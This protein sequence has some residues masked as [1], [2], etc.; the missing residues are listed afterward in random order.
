MP[1]YV[2]N[3]INLEGNK[4]IIEKV[5]ESLEGKNGDVDFNTIVPMPK[6]LN[7]SSGSMED[8]AIAVYLYKEKKDDSKL[9]QILNCSWVKE[10]NINTIDELCD[11]FIKKIPKILDSG[12]IYVE[13]IEKYGFSTW[14]G[15]CNANWG[16]KW[17]A[18]EPWADEDSFGFCTAWGDVNELILKLSERFPDVTFNY[19]YA[20]EDFGANVGKYVIKNGEIIDEYIP[21]DCSDEAYDLA[22]E[23]LGYDD[24]ELWDEDDEDDDE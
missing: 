9:K 1:N 7:I 10:Q 24:R 8:Q 20:D 14:Y 18:C 16:T 19:R 4:D 23:I 2:T 22:T 5:L 3:I 6:S 15:W 21:D 17:N 12:K 11:Y 13:N